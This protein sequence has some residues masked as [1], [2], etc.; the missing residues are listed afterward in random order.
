MLTTPAWLETA[1]DEEIITKIDTDPRTL[2]A[3]GAFLGWPK[4]KIFV[5][6]IGF[7]QADFDT[8]VGH[9]SP[10]D[11]ALLYA[12]YNQPRH[13]DELTDAFGKLLSSSQH[14]GR[15]TI[16][17]LGCGPFTAGLA[18]AAVF[19]PSRE[20]RYFGID[21]ATSMCQFGARLV[22]AARRYGGLNDRTTC[23]FES[24]LN[25]V[26]FG[27]IRGDLTIVVASYLLASP[28]LDVKLLIEKLLNALSRIGPGPVAVLFTNSAAPHLNTKYPEF[29][30]ALCDAGFAIE[31]DDTEFFINTTKTPK[32]LRY[33]LF[34]RRA[35]TQITF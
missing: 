2:A 28:T 5:D 23:S 12:R 34:F 20:F 3:P 13:L 9:L 19:G 35:Q 25:N 27:P 18:F 15:P 33:A 32:D 22:T 17:D 26:K 6:V 8:T 14:A 16:L 1:I 11:R 29:R 30:Q 21:I 7:G 10:H 31:V 24:D 4:N